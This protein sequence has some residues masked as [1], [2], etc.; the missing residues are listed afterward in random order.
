MTDTPI[1]VCIV[2][3]VMLELATLDLCKLVLNVNKEAMI[4]NSKM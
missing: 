2:T 4:Q 1:Y 3:I